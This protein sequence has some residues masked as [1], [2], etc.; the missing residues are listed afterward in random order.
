MGKS[1]LA[2][3]ITAHA[4]DAGFRVAWGRCRESEGA[5]P[6][7][8]WQ[9]VLRALGARPLDPDAVADVAGSGRFRLF[10]RVT[11]M[12]AAAA[13]SAPLLVVLDDVH[14][15]DEASL[16]LLAFVG[17]QLRPA[18]LGFVI[19]Y[20]DAELR[21][22]PIAAAVVAD[23]ARDR[24]T[25]AIVLDGLS[26]DEVRDWLELASTVSVAAS[27]QVHERTGGN[28]L[29]VSEV[30]RLLAEGRP[31]DTPRTVREVI[32]QRAGM[33]PDE[34]RRA[35]EV[36]AVLG[37]EFGYPPLAAA[38]RINPLAAVE[39]LT[40]A[41]AAQLIML[42]DAHAGGYRFVHTLIREAILAELDPAVRARLHALAL[43]ALQDTGW[44]LPTDLAEHA[45]RARAVIGDRAGLGYAVSAAEQA[46]RMLAWEDATAW[47]QVAVELIPPVGSPAELHSAQL[48]LGRALLRAGR[49]EPARECF[50]AVAARAVADGD[51]A[52]LA[53]AALGAGETV[54][55]IATDLALVRLLDQA[56]SRPGIDDLDRVRLEARRA[57]AAF[58]SPGG[59]AEARERSL[60]AVVAA[61]RSGDDGA[62]GAALVARQFTLRGPDLLAERIEAGTAVR[63]IADRLADD[64]LRF[65][66]H[67]WLIPDR[68][69]AG[70]I[71]GTRAEL[72]AAETIA[73][74]RRDPIQRWWVVVLRG[75]LAGFAGRAAEAERMAGEVATLGR[76]LGRDAAEVY[77]AAQLVPIFWRAGRLGELRG[78][79]T[80]LAPRFPGLPTLECTLALVL[81]ETGDQV[82]ARDHLDRLAADDFA[83]LPRD[84]LFLA[85]LAILGEVAVALGDRRHA[86]QIVAA[87]DPYADRNLIQGV[88]VGWGSGAWHLARIARVAGDGRAARA[89]SAT[90][91]RLHRQWG[92]GLFVPTPGSASSGTGDGL[93]PRE[94]EVV[95]ILAMGRS[96]KEIASELHISVHTVERHIAN[97]FVK[98]GT[99]NRAEAVRWAQ[100]QRLVS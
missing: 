73:L 93:S 32:K 35:L 49:V 9:Q 16:R 37:R 10:E 87:L 90:A 97:I 91:D 4:R 44:G 81:A 8:P 95:T 3:E 61:R 26:V 25:D 53:K 89:Y 13:E 7:W 15:A 43:S 57:I 6:F 24:R 75:L 67:Q 27:G 42:D 82:L 88:P 17:D 65:R 94:L 68:F 54:A 47:W 85:S 80:D 50:E 70:D 23:L 84:Q 99:R 40:P 72:D 1:R 30:V 22:A 41:V 66:A 78:T 34:T 46:D 64:E 100:R 62:L 5:P 12:L 20:R 2:E 79:F 63:A 98:L 51:D 36:A 19:C 38:L 69:Q 83:M 77:A 76:R 59:P 52:L 56:L 74:A 55:E 86:G 28:P 31:E 92:A 71:T 18:R 48:R 45:V 14:R 11:S 58:W 33:L 39:T 29:F 96:N 21:Q 60:R